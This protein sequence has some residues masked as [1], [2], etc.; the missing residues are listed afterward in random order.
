[1]KIFPW[2]QLFFRWLNQ[3]RGKV[4][5]ALFSTLFFLVVLFPFEDLSDLASSQ[6]AALTHNQVFVQFR[7]MG[8][9]IFPPSI[10]I[11]ENIRVE[12]A[13][14]PAL[15]ADQV[16]LRPGVIALLQKKI[17]GSLGI[18]GFLKGDIEISIRPNGKSESGI[19]K[20]MIELTAKKLSLADLKNL[21]NLPVAM[22]G[23]LEL[24]GKSNT[25]LSFNES[26]D[27]DI[28]MKIEK[29]EMPPANIPTG[30]GPM[31]VP[32][33]KFSHVELKGRLSNGK[34]NIE[35]GQLGKAQDELVGTLK[36]SMDLQFR[37]KGNPVPLPGGY[38]FQLQLKVK[39]Q[40]Q[41]KSAALLSLLDGFKSPNEDGSAQYNFKVSAPNTYENPQFLPLK[42]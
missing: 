25:D 31:S 14:M 1:M 37:G 24:D 8:F 32:D 16:E 30:M 26:P 23:E 9:G 34:L 27:M 18:K 15:S 33:L 11:S 4:F 22:K 39:P 5:F 38:D 35:S 6:I 20:H 40:F 42:Q 12:T 3:Q 36:G 19:E 21:A 41:Q 17:A 10:H 7:K 28:H 29:F 13:Q 2:I